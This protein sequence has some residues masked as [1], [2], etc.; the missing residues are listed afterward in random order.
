MLVEGHS[1]TIDPILR[2]DIC[3]VARQ[4]L[5]NAFRHSRAHKIEAEITFS[6]VNFVLRVRDDGRGIEPGFATAGTA[7]L[8]SGD[9]MGCESAQV[10]WR[11]DKCLERKRSRH[12]DR[13]EHPRLECLRTRLGNPECE[14]PFDTTLKELASLALPRSHRGGSSCDSP[15]PRLSPL[16]RG[17]TIDEL[18]P[19]FRDVGAPCVGNRKPLTL[20]IGSTPH[21]G[22]C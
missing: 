8:D 4:A 11:E 2:D 12:R 21:P 18:L 6:E 3:R 13:V 7:A 1:R 16:T 14:P 5:V 9:S 10:H 22:L 17:Y 19:D 15:R 20:A